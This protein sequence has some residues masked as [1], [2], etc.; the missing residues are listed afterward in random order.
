M[1]IYGSFVNQLGDT[2]TVHIVTNNSRETVKVIGSEE[3]GIFFTDDPVEIGDEVND[4]FDVLLRQSATIH[5]YCGN[6]IPDFF[7][8]SAMDTVVNIYKEDECL[9]AGFWSHKATRSP[10]MMYMMR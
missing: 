4:T 9:F 10:T 6:L 1:Y 5:L 7:C 8:T 2:I 3:D